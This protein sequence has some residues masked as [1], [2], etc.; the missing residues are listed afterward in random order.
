MCLNMNAILRF[1]ETTVAFPLVHF[2]GALD[3]V[4]R[5]PGCKGAGNADHPH[6]DVNAFFFILLYKFPGG[7]NLNLVQVA[8]IGT[9]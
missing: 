5:F 4:D 2:D 3:V 7:V 6:L 9:A 8:C 1:F